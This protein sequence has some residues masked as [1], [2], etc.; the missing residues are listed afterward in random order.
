MKSKTSIKPSLDID[1]LLQDSY[2]LVV[3][4]RQG[5]SASSSDAL[6]DFCVQQ[7]EHVRQVLRDAGMNLRSIDHISHAQCA[8]LD[9]SVFTHAE[10]NARSKWAGEP[11]QARFFNRHQAGECLYEEMREVLREPMPDRCVLTVYQRVMLLGFMGRYRDVNDP[12]RRQLVAQLQERVPPMQLDAAP[13]TRLIAG[14]SRSPLR[15]LRSPIVHGLAA[16]L[17][18]VSVWFWLDQSLADLIATLTL[19]Q[20]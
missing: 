4:L 12:E 2:L 7:I 19:E 15:F 14:R 13:I 11:L 1:E 8:L 10:E 9:E 5:G 6:W 16:V 18:L 3:E 20:V 17:L